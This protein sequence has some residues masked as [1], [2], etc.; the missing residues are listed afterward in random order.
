MALKKFK[1][2]REN[3]IL[4]QDTLRD[5]VQTWGDKKITHENIEYSLVEDEITSS[6]YEDG[7]A[8]HSVV[9]K[10]LSDDKYFAFDYTDWDLEHNYHRDFPNSAT[11][12][13]ARTITKIIFE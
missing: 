8:D 9:F 5:I 3:L 13:F 11:E 1:Q 2:E 12:V 7:G 6:D 4:T 10:R